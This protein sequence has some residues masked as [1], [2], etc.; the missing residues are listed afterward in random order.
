MSD[1]NLAGQGSAKPA[2]T[3]GEKGPRVCST[4]TAK[5]SDRVPPLRP[6][7]AGS[8]VA[9]SCEK[10]GQFLV[11]AWAPSWTLPDRLVAWILDHVGRAN[12]AADLE[13]WGYTYPGQPTYMAVSRPDY[14]GSG[15]TIQRFVEPGDMTTQA[16]L[17]DGRIGLAYGPPE[18]LPIPE[19]G[20]VQPALRAVPFGSNAQV[21]S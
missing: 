14:C 18:H 3:D 19:R 4:A 15:L 9:I 17:D 13:W 10:P 20:M 11:R 6:S 5:P 21:Q 1:P 16:L 7:L 2:Q 12:M 8:K